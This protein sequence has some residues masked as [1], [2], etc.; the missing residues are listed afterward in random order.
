MARGRKSSQSKYIEW[1]IAVYIRLSKD[2]GSDESASVTNQ[3]KILSEYIQTHF[4]ILEYE[5]VDFYIDDGI[6]GTSVDRESFQ[7]MINDVTENKVNC[8]ICK[9]LCRMFRDYSEQGYYLEK[10]FPIK[11]IRFI[12]IGYPQIDSFIK[13]ESLTGF[14]V[15]ING[16]IND[17]YAAK[18]SRDIKMT[19]DNKRRNCEF[20]GA[21]TSYGYKKSP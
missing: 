18:L 7:R 17:R 3:K 16:I 1:K 11:Q 8:I 21:Y 14:E 10:F 6:T 20:I 12:N 2:D 4:D 19:L 9:N 13:P 5:I 15:P